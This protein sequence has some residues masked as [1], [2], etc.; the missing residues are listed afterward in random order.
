MRGTLVAPLVMVLIVLTAGGCATYSQPEG[1]DVATLWIDDPDGPDGKYEFMISKVDGL[2]TVGGG[3][4]TGGTR[5]EVKLSP[6][7]HLLRVFNGMGGQIQSGVF[8]LEE[9]PVEV[10]AKKTYRLIVDIGDE[11]PADPERW[12]KEINPLTRAELKHRSLRIHLEE[13]KTW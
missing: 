11:A 5:T 3:L 10:Q 4:F 9:I 2:N 8:A 7:K 6:G 1:P 13:V 12:T